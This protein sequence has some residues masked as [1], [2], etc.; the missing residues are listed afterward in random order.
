M[1]MKAYFIFSNI[2][3]YVTSL[4]F[5][6]IPIYSNILEFGKMSYNVYYDINNSHWLNVT[7][8]NVTDISITNDTVRA[9]LFS[10][11]LGTENVVAFKGTST[12]WTTLSLDNSNNLDNLLQNTKTNT[13]IGIDSLTAHNDKFNDNLYYSCCFYKQSKLFTCDTQC[14]KSNKSELIH[15]K[16]ECCANC[17]KDSVHLDNN[18]INYIYKIMENVNKRVTEDSKIVF[19]G[20]SLG[21]T[22]ATLAGV[23]YNKP[24]VSFQSP[25]D[26]HYFTRIGFINEFN[27]SNFSNIYQFGHNGDPLFMGDCDTTCRLL[28]YNVNTKCHVGKS[29]LYDSKKKLNIYE[30][31]L[32]HRIEYVINTII[33]KWE[34]DFPECKF[35]TGCIDCESWDYVTNDQ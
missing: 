18:Y 34:N 11:D 23:I 7:L 27:R 20:H 2:F 1:Q 13:Q 30:S 4:D 29:C 33:P 19:T 17:Y 9:Y 26:I 14:S 12:F 35:E 3:S 15:E 16:E 31:I 32:N 8:L 21:G 22:L 10:N 24:A 28:G 5:E 6:N 25:G